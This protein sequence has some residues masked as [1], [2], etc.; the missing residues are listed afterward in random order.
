MPHPESLE[1]AGMQEDYDTDKTDD[2]SEDW[3]RI[4]IVSQY[5]D[6]LL[7][8]CFGAHAGRGPKGLDALDLTGLKKD[9]CGALLDIGGSHYKVAPVDASVID[10][11]IDAALDAAK[12]AGLARYF[13]HKG[14]E[15]AAADQA[16]LALQKLSIDAAGVAEED[17]KAAERAFT[18]KWVCVAVGEGPRE[19]AHLLQ[20][21]K[22]QLQNL[23][24]RFEGVYSA[25]ASASSRS[26]P[27]V[28][29]KGG[30]KRRSRKS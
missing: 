24:E 21:K 4:Q 30:A 22:R 16:G 26:L 14:E 17:V 5:T 18:G 13:M 29:E 2:E 19:D 9:V 15:N 7:K 23:Y 11:D 25:V 27:A 8:A 1:S 28:G 10:L 12:Y 3:Q 20:T 6:T